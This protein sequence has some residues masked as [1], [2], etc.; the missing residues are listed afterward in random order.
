[1]IKLLLGFF[2]GSAASRLQSSQVNVLSL[3]NN[4][5][6]Q[7]HIRHNNSKC[8]LEDAQFHLDLMQIFQNDIY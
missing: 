6:V 2:Y 1:M 8:V 5:S 7:L 3:Y 4:K